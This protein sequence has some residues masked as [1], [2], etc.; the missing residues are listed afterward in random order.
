M[1]RLLFIGA[2]N[3]PELFEFPDCL[4]HDR[5]IESPH[6]SQACSP[7]SSHAHPALPTWAKTAGQSV[8]G[9]NLHPKGLSMSVF[10]KFWAR[11]LLTVIVLFIGLAFLSGCATTRTLIPREDGASVNIEQ[12]SPPCAGWS[13]PV[14]FRAGP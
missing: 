11:S 1:A 9:C 7:M 12:R 8:L 5:A 6:L 14:P 10:G 2:G 4:P 3:R 13:C